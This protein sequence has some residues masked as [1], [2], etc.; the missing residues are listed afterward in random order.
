MRAAVDDSDSAQV[1]TVLYTQSTYVQHICIAAYSRSM[2]S[3]GRNIIVVVVVILAGRSRHAPISIV[4]RV[5]LPPPTSN[6]LS[7]N[8][9]FATAA[10]TA[11]MASA[12]NRPHVLKNDTAV[13]C[14]L[15]IAAIM[16]YESAFSAFQHNC[17]I[18]PLIISRIFENY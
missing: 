4:D 1:Y 11:A 8:T 6:V 2:L 13:M 18:M 3:R 7:L 15:Q 12:E 5:F 17:V 14:R 9:T 16:I 10:T